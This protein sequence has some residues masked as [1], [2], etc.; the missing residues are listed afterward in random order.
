MAFFSNQY[1]TLKS[2]FFENKT[3]QLKISIKHIFYV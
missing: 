2:Y 3:E 1:K